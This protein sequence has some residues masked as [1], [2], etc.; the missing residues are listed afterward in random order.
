MCD[1]VTAALGVVSVA[2][3]IGGQIAAS[4]SAKAQERAIRSQQ[5]LVREETRRKA[6]NEL[7]DQMREMRRQQGKIRSAAGEAG[8]GLHSGAVEG[9]L[10]DTAMQ[11]ELQGDRT[12]ANMES[13]HAANTA[14]AASMLSQI[15]KPTLLGAGLQ[16]GASALSAYS[17]ASKAKI[18]K[19][20]GVPPPQPSGGS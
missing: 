13:R 9:L 20:K 15:Q 18:A 8:L 3:T 12:L 10:F 2:S 5:K 14:D 16:V 7:F 4:K 1:P 11:K 6:T 19:D 17:A